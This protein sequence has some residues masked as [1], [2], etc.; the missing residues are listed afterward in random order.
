MS[1]IIIYSTEVC[2][3]CHTL[4]QWLDKQNITYTKRVTDLD[5]EAMMEFMSVNDGIIGVPFSVVVN[6]KGE[7]TK[8][9]G[10]DQKRF[11]QA[12]NI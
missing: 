9:S 5:D 10:F 1:T 6:D 4:T 11:R 8:I 3:A 7:E 12:L 2:A